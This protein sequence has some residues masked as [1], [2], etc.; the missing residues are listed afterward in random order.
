MPKY[1][2]QAMRPLEICALSVAGTFF[3]SANGLI[4]LFHSACQN[5]LPMQE[6][7]LIKE[8]NVSVY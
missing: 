1:F 4:I 2:N 8:K 5:I 3:F 6:R 7:T